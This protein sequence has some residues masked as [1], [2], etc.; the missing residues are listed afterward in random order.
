MNPLKY[1]FSVT[2]GMFFGFSI[3]HRVMKIDEF[4]IKA[5][6]EMLDHKNL[7]ELHGLQGHLAYI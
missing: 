7:K 3:H 6:Q 5:I 4:M 2:F 1:T